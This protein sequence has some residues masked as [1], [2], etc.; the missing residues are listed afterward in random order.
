MC[1]VCRNIVSQIKIIG[2]K[3]RIMKKTHVKWVVIVAII[4]MLAAM[5]S[6]V[7]TLDESD[8][9]IVQQAVQVEKAGK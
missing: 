8:P 1:E 2:R 6:Y 5:G 4:L 3:N 7:L 9:N